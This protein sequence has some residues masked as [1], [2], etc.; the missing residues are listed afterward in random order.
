[1]LN[2]YFRWLLNHDVTIRPT[3]QD[4]LSSEFAPPPVFEDIELFNYMTYAVSNS[5]TKVYKL[6]MSKLFKQ[7]MSLQQYLTYGREL[8]K[9]LYSKSLNTNY[10]MVKQIAEKVSTFITPF[11]E[12]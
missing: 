12:Q 4:I 6:L 1:M 5:Q 2:D 11:T 8:S 9:S 10:D 3:A 7:K